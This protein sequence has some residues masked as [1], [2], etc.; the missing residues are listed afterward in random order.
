LFY[1]S[2]WLKGNKYAVD[3]SMVLF[4]VEDIKMNRKDFRVE[5]IKASR[6][7]CVPPYPTK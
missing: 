1:F 2:R 5:D 7:E 4:R 6:K 3:S